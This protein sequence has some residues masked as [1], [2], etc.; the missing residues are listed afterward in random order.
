MTTDAS[1]AR[2]P[3]ELLARLRATSSEVIPS[4]LREAIVA[5]G[6]AAVPGLIAIL[7]DYDL[8][9]A[10]SAAGGWPPVH[11]V[12]LLVDLRA[13]SAIGPMLG[14]LRQGD[15]DEILSSRVAVRLPNLGAA[16][17][18]PLLAELGS[19]TDAD[20]RLALCEMLSLLGVRDERVWNAISADFD[21][22][23][24]ARAG[25]LARY[26][27]LRGA[28]LIEEAI[29]RSEP[30]DR[31]ALYDLNDLIEM[32]S[33][34]AGPLPARIVEHVEGVL[35]LLNVPEEAPIIASKVGRNDPC[36]C[37]SGKKY[38]RCCLPI[39]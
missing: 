38:K 33:L 26:G 8:A 17:L 30:V 27:D 34:L 7:E 1:V 12:D 9:M 16:A 32:Y 19:T 2:E 39:A 29:Y 18:E 35:A 5:Q 6:A 37:G 22:A 36:P 3:A 23:P 13:E 20:R 15:L 4:D 14:V 25:F 24:V 10:D 21:A 11:A 31:S 28:P